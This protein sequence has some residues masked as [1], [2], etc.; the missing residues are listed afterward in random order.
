MI[1][2]LLVLV[3][4]VLGGALGV[5]VG[6]I[7]GRG[8]LAEEVSAL[9]ATLEEVR[10]QLSARDGELASL[11]EA[12]EAEKVS[13]ATSN[14]HLESTREHL[15]AQRKQF[16]QTE[17]RLKDSFEALSA[18][19]LKSNNEQFV[20]LADARM[21][22][23]REQLERYEK[24]IRVLEDARAQA[25]GG[26]NKQLTTLQ[27]HNE[28]LRQETALLVSALRQPGAKGKWG[29]VTLRRVI[30]LTGMTEHTDFD[31]Q[32]SVSSE[33]RR[34]VPDLVVH[35]PGGRSLAIDSK[36]NTSA[37]L[38]AVN[39]TD[40]EDRKR[41]L[42]RY[43]AEVRSTLRTLGGKE[44]WRQFSPA[45]EFVVMFMPG[46]AFFAAAVA[47]D[48][49]LITDGVEKGVLLASPTTLIALLLAVRHGWQQ[50]QVAQNA[51]RIAVAGREL[52]ERLCTF[53]K[54]LDAVREGIERAAEAYDRTVANWEKRTLPS[55]R[56][57]K[58]F[59]ADAGNTMGELK[60]TDTSMRPRLPLEED[61]P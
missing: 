4:L 53:V 58:E 61:V 52:Y 11:R 39:A 18:A 51:Q 7:R 12:L 59:G 56:R 43:T 37:Y 38:D 54:H 23:L 22:P 29:E 13:T 40:E 55:V 26:L 36:V 5:Y 34:Q 9:E 49:D 50:E 48:G 20:T 44:Y 6:T 1:E 15:A 16:E 31:I 27:H 32:V 30:E 24:Q 25:Y 35:M 45:P 17:K 28:R 46:E 8:G 47:Q 21:K 60:K 57:L 14:A 42:T 41:Y 33:G 3:G 2:A 19:A 10:G